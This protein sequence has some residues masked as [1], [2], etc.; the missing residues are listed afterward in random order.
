MTDGEKMVWAA[1]FVA[2]RAKR[3]DSGYSEE[4]AT[5]EAVYASDETV[6]SLRATGTGGRG[7]IDRMTNSD[8][9]RLP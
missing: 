4:M 3:I 1:A 2:E 7:F 6:R 5:I 9:G 8:H